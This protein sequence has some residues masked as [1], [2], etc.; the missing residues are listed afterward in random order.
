MCLL[1][2]PP[3]QYL[4]PKRK[5]NLELPHKNEHWYNFHLWWKEPCVRQHQ[6]GG[7]WRGSSDKDSSYLNI[8]CLGVYKYGSEYLQRN[9]SST[10]FMLGL[11]PLKDNVVWNKCF[12]GQHLYYAF[13]KLPN[14]LTCYRPYWTFICGEKEDTIK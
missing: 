9:A 11:I 14:K 6:Q 13:R 12:Y 1:Q 8:E 10:V 5:S 7:R 2:N 4:H 3:L